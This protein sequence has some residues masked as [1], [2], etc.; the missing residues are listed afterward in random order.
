MKKYI[1]IVDEDHLTYNLLS[2]LLNDDQTEVVRASTGEDALRKLGGM[3]CNLCLLSISLPDMSGIDLV[4]VMKKNYANV[5][6]IIMTCHSPDES[7]MKTIREHA[8]LH[9][10]KPFDLFQVK[11][12]IKELLG[13]GIL[14][15]QNYNFLITR[16]CGE[17]RLHDR[18]PSTNPGKYTILSSDAEDDEL[19][20]VADVVDICMNGLGITTDVQL[21]PG[22][23][24][25]LT[26]GNEHL[27]GI[28]QWIASGSQSKRYRA[29]IRFI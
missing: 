21:K 18:Q 22:K 8:L 5:Y 2:P 26:N 9:L 1:L 28:V 14:T 6:I 19:S 11:S 29:G 12:V 13:K 3:I 17:K 16:L 7:V 15:Y 27:R 24:I 23:I 20:S 10:V 4:K 25:R